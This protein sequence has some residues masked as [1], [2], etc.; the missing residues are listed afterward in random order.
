MATIG[1]ARAVAEIFPT[2]FKKVHFSGLMAWF[3]WL[4]VHLTFLIGFRNKIGVLF[5]WF[6]AY[7]TNRR[8]SRLITR[9]VP[10]LRHFTPGPIGTGETND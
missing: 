2:I 9:D 4:F 6:L 5:D 1:K 3:A 8:G 10:K 7:V